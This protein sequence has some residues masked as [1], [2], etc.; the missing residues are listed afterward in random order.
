MSE[1]EQP[2]FFY[3]IFDPSMPRLGPGDS[4]S[5]IKALD[6]LLA[7]GSAQGGILDGSTKIRI[8]DIG[9]GNGAQTIQ[10]AKHCDCS[11]LAVDY[12]QPFLDELRRRAEAEGVSEKIRTQRGDMRC[13]ELDEGDF[14]MI[15]CEG[16][17]FIAGFRNG[18]EAWRPLLA[19][20]GF[21][22]VTEMTWFKPDPP[23]ECRQFFD[24]ICPE[25]AGIDAN[26]D[27]IKSCGYEVLDHFTLPESA[28]TEH[29]YNALELRVRLFREKWTGDP[30]K[31]GLLDMLQKEIDIYRKYSSYYGYAFYLMRR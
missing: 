6:T 30:E 16:A 8:L 28:W 23:D 29:F 27:M 14:D 7:A 31:I 11:I 15:W 17:I 1:Q 13:L 19:P 24:P 21:C 22:A 18:L 4:A 26:L 9:C 12:Q 2:A 3:E 25:M 20:G 10:I 5:T